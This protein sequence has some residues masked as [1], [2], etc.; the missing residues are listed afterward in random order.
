MLEG[1]ILLTDKV[2]TVGDLKEAL[3]DIPDDAVMH[4]FGSMN[5]KVVY[6]KD[7]NT[8]YL[9]EDISFLDEDNFDDFK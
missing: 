9:D 7:N 5:C 4:P 1:I 6:S 2:T 8:A 3:K